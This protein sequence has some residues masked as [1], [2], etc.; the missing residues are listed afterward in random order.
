MK[1]LLLLL[2]ITLST[3]TQAQTYADKASKEAIEK[4]EGKIYK[5]NAASHQEGYD[6]IGY[7]TTFNNPFYSGYFTVKNGMIYKCSKRGKIKALMFN[8]DIY[9]S[10]GRLGSKVSLIRSIEKHRKILFHI[11]K[12][13]I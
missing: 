7:V 11:K 10:Y 1:N 13:I 6:G 9:A 5:M 2:A 4:M 3:L 8:E 12:E